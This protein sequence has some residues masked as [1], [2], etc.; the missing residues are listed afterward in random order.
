LDEN[1]IDSC[2]V[3]YEVFTAVTM[4]NAEYWDVTPCGPCKN[5]VWEERI[6]SIRVTRIGELGTTLAVTSNR[7]KLRGNTLYTKA[8]LRS[9][10]RL[11]VTANVV[12]SSSIRVSLVME[13]M[14]SPET[15]VLTRAT[16]R[17]IP[18][19]CF[20]QDFSLIVRRIFW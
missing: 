2:Y 9:L 15:S 11:L 4:K 19:D 1:R 8:F 12:H 18:D 13:A 16:W 14:R 20:L 7:S 10:L 6:T 5:R 3:R 17:H